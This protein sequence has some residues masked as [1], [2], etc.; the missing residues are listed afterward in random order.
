MSR[1]N[2]MGVPVDALTMNQTVQKIMM[3]IRGYTDTAHGDEPSKG[4][5]YDGRSKCP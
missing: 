5:S 1:I 4:D 3:H 2:I